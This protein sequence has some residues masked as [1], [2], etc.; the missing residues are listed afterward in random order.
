MSKAEEPTWEEYEEITKYIYENLGARYGIR[1]K[2]YGRKCKVMGKSGVE[3]QVDVLTEQVQGENSILTAIECKSVNRKVTKEVVM[4]LR[5]VMEDAG[6]ANGIIVCKAGYTK[7]TVKFAEHRGI[8]LVELWKAEEN[9]LGG[10]HTIEVGMVELNIKSTLTR[11]IINYIDLGQTVITDQDEIMSMYYATVLNAEGKEVYFK[12]C[13]FAFGD[14]LHEVNVPL[15]NVTNTYTP[16]G[17]SLILNYKGE[18]LVIERIIIN[19]F[20]T[21]QNST[22]KNSITVT[23]Q[24]WMIM[25]EIFEKRTAA[26]SKTGLMYNLP[27]SS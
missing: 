12:S 3:H 22:I 6:I 15:K 13:L 19:G 25:N 2:G 8:K 20:L 9:D 14:D 11:P 17:G 16:A 7:D 24:V 4:K 18:K 10:N 26:L 5:E 21:R 1:V 23:D 27:Q